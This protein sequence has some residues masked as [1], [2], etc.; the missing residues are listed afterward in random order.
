MKFVS[1]LLASLLFLE[2]CAGSVANKPV[3]QSPRVTS[4][5]GQSET[6]NT[7]D[8]QTETPKRKLW[9]WAVSGVV[10]GTVAAGV[11]VGVLAYALSHMFDHTDWTGGAANGLGGRNSGSKG[12]GGST[13]PVVASR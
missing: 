11:L 12:G 8:P 13:I 4:N 7:S 5:A 10:V 1:T 6:Q 9:P 2:A 3:P